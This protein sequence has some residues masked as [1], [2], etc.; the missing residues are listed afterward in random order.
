MKCKGAIVYA[1]LLVCVVSININSQLSFTSPF[2]NF[3]HS[4][5]FFAVKAI[6]QVIVI[7]VIGIAEEMR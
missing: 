6:H 3:D 1:V 7:S 4:G 2:T 5:T